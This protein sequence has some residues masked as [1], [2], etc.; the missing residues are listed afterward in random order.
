MFGNGNNH[1]LKIFSGRANRPLAEKIANKLGFPLGNV[2][3]GDFPDG[4]TNV[5][6]EEDVRGRDVF[7]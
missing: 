3:L 7:L 4:E 5:R 6:I 2:A 1:K